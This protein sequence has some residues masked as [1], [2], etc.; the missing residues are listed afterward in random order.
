[1][2]R[3]ADG[4]GVDGWF[5]F[6]TIFIGGGLLCTNQPSFHPPRPPAWPTLVQ[7][8]CMLITQYKTPLPTSRLYAMHQTILVITISCKGQAQVRVG[9]RKLGS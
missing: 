6:C 1:M 4:W 7:Y 3:S 2:D 5:G 8:Y 9:P